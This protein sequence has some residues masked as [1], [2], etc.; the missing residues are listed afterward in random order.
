MDAKIIPKDSMM[1]YSIMVV[2]LFDLAKLECSHLKKIKYIDII[3]AVYLHTLL[4]Y[5]A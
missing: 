2:L 3:G 1:N 4:V 5:P